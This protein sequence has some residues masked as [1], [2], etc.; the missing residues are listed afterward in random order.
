MQLRAESQQAN[1]VTETEFAKEG[2]MV[3]AVMQHRARLENQFRKS[4]FGVVNRILCRASELPRQDGDENEYLDTLLRIKDARDLAEV[5]EQRRL[6]KVKNGTLGRQTAAIEKMESV[7]EAKKRLKE[8]GEAGLDYDQERALRRWIL[9]Y[10]GYG[11]Y[12][13][14]GVCQKHHITVYH[15]QE[16]LKIDIDKL[17]RRRQW[18]KAALAV[19][20]AIRRCGPHRLR[21]ARFNRIMQGRNTRPREPDDYGET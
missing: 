8:F 14:C 13:I 20:T 3:H 5:E 19:M 18:L 15:V 11:G 16:C 1:W 4:K 7:K 12:D 21:P 2:T 6:R 10:V 9:R 17:C